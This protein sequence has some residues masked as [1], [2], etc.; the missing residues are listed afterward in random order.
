MILC[1]ISL[2]DLMEDPPAGDVEQPATGSSIQ[3]WGYFSMI[4]FLISFS[5]TDGGH[6]SRKFGAA[7]NREQPRTVG[8][9][10]MIL[11]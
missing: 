3:R 11:L 2:S 6:T 7:N 1:L 5:E 9:F 4:L 10:L 8:I